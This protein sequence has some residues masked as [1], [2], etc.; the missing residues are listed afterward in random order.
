MKGRSALPRAAFFVGLLVV[1]G[2]VAGSFWGRGLL[3]R[4][5]YFEVR[6]IEV[7]GAHW[8]APDSVLRLAAIEDGRSVWEDYSEEEGRLVGHPLIEEAQIRRSGLRALRIVLREAEPLALVGVPELRAV[9]GDGT[10]L[11]IEPAGASLDLP[12]VTVRARLEAGSTAIAPGRA[13]RAL[14][15]YAKLQALDPGLAAAVSDFDI[16]EPGG[17]AANLVLSQPAKRLALPEQID[18]ALVKRVRATLAD[19]RSRGVGAALI[20]ARYADQVV[21]RRERS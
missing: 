17:L 21:V 8:V 18:E 20:E 1:A 12:L 6:Q 16:A 10:V 7:I 14:K 9:R 15:A 2:G 4:V 13:L 19:L 5:D 3:A 11:P